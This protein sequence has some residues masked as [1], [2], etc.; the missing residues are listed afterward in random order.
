MWINQHRQSILTY[1]RECRGEISHS[2]D[3]WSHILTLAAEY[4]SYCEKNAVT[5]G[6]VKADT[7]YIR[8]LYQELSREHRI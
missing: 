8:Q 5:N 6:V 3:E 1:A 2:S 4:E 7:E